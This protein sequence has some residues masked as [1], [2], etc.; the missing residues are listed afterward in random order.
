MDT[1]ILQ[2]PDH[3]QSGAIAD[4]REPR[5]FVAAEIPLQN[6]AIVGAIEYRA[7]RFEFT[8][9]IRRFFG[10]QLGHPPVVDVLAAAH[11][12]GEMH[13]PV[14]TI[15]DIGQRRRD[16]AFGHHGVRLA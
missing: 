8:H 4:V 16:A 7:P 15:I 14:V 10:M 11:R 2:C 5:I 3:F 13:L 6:P 1:V 12:I 9:T